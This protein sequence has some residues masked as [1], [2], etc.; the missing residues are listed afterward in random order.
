MGVTAAHTRLSST[1]GSLCLNSLYFTLVG[2]VS[3][4]VSCSSC[5][6]YFMPRGPIIPPLLICFLPRMPLS[7]S[8]TV[9]WG[10][11][12]PAPFRECMS[13]Q[14]CTY[15]FCVCTNKALFLLVIWAKCSRLVRRSSSSVL[16]FVH[17]SS[18][19]ISSI[20]R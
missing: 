18:Q 15:C 2:V 4:D 20:L 19:L 3:S 11:H 8:C 10:A 14:D 12:S 5:T 9:Y 13:S 7:N 16:L 6:T 1:R 17:F